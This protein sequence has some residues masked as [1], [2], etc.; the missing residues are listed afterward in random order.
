MEKIL[1]SKGEE[2]VLVGTEKLMADANQ[3][4]VNSLGFEIPI[5]TMTQIA[6]KVSE[7]K[8]FEVA[9]AD[10]LPIVVGQ[11]A[12][13]TNILKYRSYDLGGD[14]STGLIQSG[15]GDGRLA[16]SDAGVDSVTQQVKNWAKSAG[17]T[18]VELQQAAKAGNWD[19]VTA[20]E[21]SRKK[22]FDLGIQ[23]IAFLGLAG[24]ASIQGLLNMTGVSNNTA[25]ITKPIS[26]MT[27]TE[28]KAFTAGLLEA[29]RSNCNRTA[30]PT[31]F[32]IPES[33]YNGLASTASPDFPI[34]STLSLLEETLQLIT[35]NKS[36]KI[37][38]LAYGDAAYN[39]I[40]GAGGTTRYVLLNYDE[41]SLAMNLPVDYTNTMA[42]TV[43]G[44]Q[45][46]NVAYAQFTGVTPFR[47]AEILYFSR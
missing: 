18:L 26:A 16:V 19:L 42:N 28:L 1:N 15:G 13:S 34:R 43:D 37:L 3:R 24:D 40:G 9:P 6:K 31:H 17:W 8:F 45:F 47:P 21:K 25:L 33:D 27:T 29:Y 7:Q 39:Q 4:I 32:I 46:H 2:I 35:Q 12:W 44:F 11:G 38:P 10:Y 36:F 5:T 23:K 20:K 41:D 14:F 22:N 30:W